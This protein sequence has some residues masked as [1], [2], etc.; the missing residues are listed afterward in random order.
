MSQMRWQHGMVLPIVLTLTTLL[1]ALVVGALDTIRAQTRAGASLVSRIRAFHAA[2]AAVRV[3]EQWVLAGRPPHWHTASVTSGELPPASCIRDVFEGPNRR[4]F[5]PLEAWPHVS[6]VPQ[7]LI[8]QWP[9]RKPAR[10]DGAEPASS[11]AAPSVPTVA[12]AS[13]AAVIM[14]STGPTPDSFED[15]DRQRVYSIIGRGFGTNEDTQ[16]WL[17]AWIMIDDAGRLHRAWQTIAQRP[18]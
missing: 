18:L 5:E 12:H 14:P 9:G 6:R 16:V 4:I 10:G 7:C 3:C 1:L 8:E 11:L 15:P 2:D 17:R 13:V